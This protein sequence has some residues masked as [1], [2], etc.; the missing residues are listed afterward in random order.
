MAIKNG[1]ELKPENLSQESQKA[2]QDA[3]RE[4]R[5]AVGLERR[6]G[7]GGHSGSSLDRSTALG[8]N[9]GPGSRSLDS[10]TD[11]ETQRE[12]STGPFD[13]KGLADEENYND[14]SDYG[15]GGDA[16]RP[17]YDDLTK[18]DDYDDYDGSSSSGGSADGYKPGP[19]QDG[20]QYNGLYENGLDGPS[21]GI[22]PLGGRGLK[23]DEED[24]E[25]DPDKDPD[26]DPEKE[27]GT[28]E[29]KPNGDGDTEVKPDPDQV[30]KAEGDAAKEGMSDEDIDR[31]KEAAQG[32]N[33]KQKEKSPEEA[34]D[35]QIEENNRKAAEQAEREK[36]KKDA[37]KG[38]EDKKSDDDEDKEKK[39][40]SEEEKAKDE[41]TAAAGAAMGS[42]P[43]AM[44]GQLGNGYGNQNQQ[45]KMDEI[46]RRNLEHNNQVKKG[47]DEDRYGTP[48]GEPPKANKVE[49]EGDGKAEGKGE[50]KT[51]KNGEGKAE[52]GKKKH[53]F[54]GK[55]ANVI[56][57]TKKVDDWIHNPAR[58]GME[59]IK[60]AILHWLLSHPLVLCGVIFG[61]FFIFAL[62]FVVL[63]QDA[64]SSSRGRSTFSGSGCVYTNLKGITTS[65]TVDLANIKVELINCDGKQSDYKVIEYV[66]FEKYTV[67]VALAEVSFSKNQEYFKAQIVAARG[68][69][70]T[71]NSHMCPSRPDNCF[72]GYNAQTKTIRMRGCTNDQVYCDYDKDCMH[73]K[74]SGKPTIYGPE[75]DTVSGATVWKPKLSESTKTA[76]LAAA[77]EV[78]GKVLVDNEGNVVYTN[79]VNTDQ[80]Q[81]YAM[82]QQGMKWDEI[83][84]KHYASSG[85][86]S[87]QSAKCGTGWGDDTGQTGS[88]SYGNYSLDS[89]GDEVLLERLDGFLQ[90]N[91]TSLEAFNALI[92]KNVNDAGYA[93][94]A[95]VVAAAVT[96]IGELGDQYNVKIS[97][98]LGGG[99]ADGVAVGALGYW[100]GPTEDRPN[101]RTCKWSNAGK[102]YDACGLDCSGFVPWAFKTGGFNMGQNVAHKFQYIAGAEKV[103]L[104]ANQAVVQAGD[105]LESNQHV[106]LVIGVDEGAKQYICAESSRVF[107]GLVFSRRS[108]SESGY[109]GVK[110]DGYYANSANVRSK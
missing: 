100:G 102:R 52:P 73:Y 39:K 10:E 7:E 82:A 79:F 40:K 37:E 33:D 17:D 35:D 99:H 101:G 24:P 5:R 75:A 32:Y 38:D 14:L 88:I 50:G 59:E 43:S 31:A 27:P 78:K 70:L 66:D 45:N 64:D 108:F 47:Q 57:K 53:G 49:P 74:R 34:L 20:Y 92:E 93:T 8:Y 51:T 42:N 12:R 69:A 71:R 25:K 91:G 26:K 87:Y 61:I 84:I 9:S 21:R 29:D 2:M 54:M 13:R 89:T 44:Q 41:G 22:N 30:N 67:G 46:N 16:R 62:L 18:D 65:G 106:I 103:S 86:S 90:K 96:L 28:G 76:V 19:D 95:G 72:Y 23:K 11:S 58:M 80:N 68:F 104:N 77:D 98:Y 56:D 110:M 85:A 105:L 81:W 15:H 48:K 4:G 63:N 60:N 36:Q 55:A 3:Q 107:E 109:W 94:R 97:Y 1:E 6:P 83:L